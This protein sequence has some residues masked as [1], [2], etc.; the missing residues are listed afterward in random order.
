MLLKGTRTAT[1]HT[2]SKDEGKKANVATTLAGRM[3][4]NA[5]FVEMTWLAICAAAEGR[6][7]VVG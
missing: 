4:D 7:D 6:D 5:F 3:V 2:K 1:K